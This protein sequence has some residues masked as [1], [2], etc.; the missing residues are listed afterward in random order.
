MLQQIDIAEVQA[1]LSE[2]LEKVIQGDEILIMQ[3]EKPLVR[4]LPALAAPCPESP[5]PPRPAPGLAK[6]RVHLTTDFNDS[7]EDYSDDI[8]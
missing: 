7:F 1:H 2:L 5:K 6:G 4:M 8:P 3:N